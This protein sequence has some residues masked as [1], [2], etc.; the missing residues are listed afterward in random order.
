MGWGQLPGHGTL[1]LGFICLDSNASSVSHWLCKPNQGTGPLCAFIS[2]CLKG[3][4]ISWLALW[5][6]EGRSVAAKECGGFFL[7]D[8]Q[9]LQSIVV[10]VVHPCEY[11]SKK[12]KSLD[13][14]FKNG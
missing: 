4:I 13:C 3:T 6:G 1:A 5:V 8:E 10:M 14:T 11:T 2:S 12:K 9:V 7:R